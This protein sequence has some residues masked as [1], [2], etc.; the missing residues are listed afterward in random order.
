MTDND[1]LNPNPSSSD[2]TTRNVIIGVAA[3]VIIV[4]LVFLL[5]SRADSKTAMANETPLLSRATR[6]PTATATPVPATNTPTATETPVPPTET[7]VPPTETPTQTPA[8]PT[9]TPIP[10]T[11]RPATAAPPTN[12]PL[13]PTATPA[14]LSLL[15]SVEVDNG[16]FGKGF[17]MVKYQDDK[18]FLVKHSDGHRYRV[19]MGF[20]SSPQAL[21]R[22]Q[23]FWR[24]AGRGSANWR[25]FVFL[26]SSVNWISCSSDTNVCQE[27]GIDSGQAAV[28]VQL[29]PKQHVWE[30]LIADYLAGG[31]QATTRN[32][33]IP[34]FQSKIF[35]SFCNCDVPPEFP[36]IGFTFMRVD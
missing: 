28:N 29:F 20:L 12:T 36:L 33:Y 25:G 23:E 15:N 22:I 11:R 26:R 27:T 9:E 16:D 1:R 19:E 24:Y 14:P 3:I 8:P 7:P 2:K 5:L 34:E 21:S 32:K 17:V 35:K 31:M 6:T 30:S 10:P 13:P 4:Q 18:E